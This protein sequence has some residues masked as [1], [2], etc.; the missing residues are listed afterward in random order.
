LAFL[1]LFLGHDSAAQFNLGLKCGTVTHSEHLFLPKITYAH[2]EAGQDR[3][4]YDLAKLLDQ[5]A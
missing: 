4:G 1:L 5:L 2:I 3:N